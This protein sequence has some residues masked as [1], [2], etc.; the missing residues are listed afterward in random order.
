MIPRAIRPPHETQ[1][2][3]AHTPRPTTARITGRTEV[4]ERWPDELQDAMGDGRYS[5]SWACRA[6][7]LVVRRLVSGLKKS[8]SRSAEESDA[9]RE[10]VITAAQI[11]AQV[12]DIGGAIAALGR[13]ACL[14]LEM[15]NWDRVVPIWSNV[16]MIWFAEV[17]RNV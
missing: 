6:P 14:Y 13:L 11:K 15:R 5:G 9:E 8:V 1:T 7:F 17:S 12:H 16:V 4:V 10:T 2:G 3:I